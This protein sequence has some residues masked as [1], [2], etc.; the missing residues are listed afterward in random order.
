MP[1]QVIA[2]GPRRGNARFLDGVAEALIPPDAFLAHAH[3]HRPGAINIILDQHFA[4]CRV[5]PVETVDILRLR[6]P[7]GDR[8]SASIGFDPV[9][10]CLQEHQ[11]QCNDVSDIVTTLASNGKM[12][13]HAER[14]LDGLAGL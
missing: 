8:R 2:G 11:T 9:A 14:G 6:S 10:F 4:L 3:E 1:Q 12:G 5:Q 7:P 13:C